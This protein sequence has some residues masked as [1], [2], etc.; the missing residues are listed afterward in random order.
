M[1]FRQLTFQTSL[2]NENIC[3]QNNVLFFLQISQE[4]QVYNA[5]KRPP[6]AAV[7]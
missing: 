5:R 1:K 3:R 7:G 4:Q 2:L 6:V